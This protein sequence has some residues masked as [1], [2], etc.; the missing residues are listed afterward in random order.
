MKYEDLVEYMHR[1]RIGGISK[2]EMS[3]AIT[4]WQLSLG[5]K[6]WNR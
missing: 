4:L 6:Q 5:D 2:A 3:V 1:F